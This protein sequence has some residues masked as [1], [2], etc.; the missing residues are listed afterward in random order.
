MF[1]MNNRAGGVVIF[2][3]GLIMVGTRVGGNAF[4]LVLGICFMILGTA[5]VVWSMKSRDTNNDE[6]DENG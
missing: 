4:E 5:V 1:V 6:A 3:V 2:L